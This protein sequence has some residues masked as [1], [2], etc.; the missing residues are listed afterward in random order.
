MNRCERKNKYNDDKELE[1]FVMNEMN[2]INY[3]MKYYDEYNKKQ[4]TY[5]RFP[6]SFAIEKSSFRNIYKGDN[7]H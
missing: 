1:D 3:E 5:S 6:S 7:L 2:T 4:V